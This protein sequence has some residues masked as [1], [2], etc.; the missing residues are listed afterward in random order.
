ML[1]T[2]FS[3]SSPIWRVSS[4]L[5]EIF[6]QFL[7]GMYSVF[8][9]VFQLNFAS[10]LSTDVLDVLHRAMSYVNNL[11]HGVDFGNEHTHDDDAEEGADCRSL[12][13]THFNI[14]IICISFTSSIS[15]TILM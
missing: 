1:L 14:N 6:S 15:S 8:V 10:S 9:Q 2:V 13:Q 11:A 4:Q 5:L 7:D 3:L 12:V